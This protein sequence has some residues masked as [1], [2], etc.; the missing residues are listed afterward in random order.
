MV[1][2]NQR[3]LSRAAAISTAPLP[4]SQEAPSVD[5]VDEIV[6]NTPYASITGDSN[7]ANPP[8]FPDPSVAATDVAA[9]LS[10]ASNPSPNMAPGVGGGNPLR[11]FLQ[12]S[13]TQSGALSA[14]LVISQ[15]GEVS[16]GHQQLPQRVDGLLLEPQFCLQTRYKPIPCCSL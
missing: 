9:H 3:R 8:S 2:S 15:A 7:S 14:N 4:T 6:A 12:P 16:V 10:I 13:S 5:A 11:K 1:S